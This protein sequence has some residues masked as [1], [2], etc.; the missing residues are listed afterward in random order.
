[1]ERSGTAGHQRSRHVEVADS[2]LRRD[3]DLK[4]RIYARAAIPSYWIVNL[5]DRRIEVYTAPSGPG[6]SPDY[7]ERA[8][9]AAEDAVPVVIEGREVGRVAVGMVLPL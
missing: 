4:K 5:A 7:A 6:A 9:Y 2:S 3:R 8:D 1:V